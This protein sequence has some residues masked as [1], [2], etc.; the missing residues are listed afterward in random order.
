MGDRSS[1]SL[2]PLRRNDSH[3]YTK[4]DGLSRKG[5]HIDIGEKATT[6]QRS[7]LFMSPQPLRRRRSD[8]RVKLVCIIE[9]T[10]AETMEEA[11]QEL[12]N[13]REAVQPS[14]NYGL[15]IYRLGG[16][17]DYESTAEELVK[18]I[19]AVIPAHPELLQLDDP[20]KLFKVVPGL[21][22]DL[23]PTLYQASWALS[24][25]KTLYQE[26]S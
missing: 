25:A 2:L 5:I 18:R 16:E 24:K 14:V 23:E 4:T 19:L 8:P 21:C 9:V 1:M 12:D 7:S 10:E 22:D 20:F 26:R 6:L 3:A 11:E 13:F 15:V 17:V